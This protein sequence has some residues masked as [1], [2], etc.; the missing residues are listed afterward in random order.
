M[1]RALAN[2]SRPWLLIFDNT[3]DP[4][5]PLIPYFPPGDRGDVIITSRNPGCQ[6]YWTVGTKEVGRMTSTDALM[7]LNKTVSGVTVE[8]DDGHALRG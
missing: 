5:P 2:T 4:S 1:K 8:Q 3:D 6:Q 7:Q